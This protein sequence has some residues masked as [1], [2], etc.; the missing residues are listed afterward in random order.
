MLQTLFKNN[1]S[2]YTL[3]YKYLTHSDIISS[4]KRNERQGLEKN[5]FTYLSVES[6]EEMERNNKKFETAHQSCISVL[7]AVFCD[8]IGM[9][10]GR[11]GQRHIEE[12]AKELKQA[13][14]ETNNV[15]PLLL[16]NYARHER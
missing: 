13:G 8:K 4:G 10:A 16:P 9:P 12:Y 3:I 6:M 5:I 1:N 2:T 14:I 15:S 11:S 7:D